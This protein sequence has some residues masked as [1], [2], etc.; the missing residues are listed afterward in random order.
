M[1][2]SPANQF[3]MRIANLVIGL[4]PPNLK[5]WGKAMRCEIDAIRVPSEATVFA[6]G[7]IYFALGQ[8]IAFFTDTAFKHLKENT[9]HMMATCAILATGLGL[10]HMTLA[11]APTSYLA[12]NAGAL[13]TGFLIVGIAAMSTKISK[14]RWGLISV[15]LALMVLLTSL[16]G[17][18]AEGATRWILLGSF[19]VQSSLLMVPIVAVVFARHQSVLTSLAIAVTSFA[20]ALQPDRGMSGA[21]AAGTLVLALAKP[22]KSSAVAAGTAMCGFV[23]AML[24]SDTLPATQ[25]VDQIYFS[26]FDV[27]PIAGIAVLAGT[28]LLIAPAI[29]GWLGGGLD[30]NMFLVFGAVWG[31]ICFAAALGNYPTPIVGYGGSAIIGY[32]VCMLAFAKPLRRGS[33]AGETASGSARKLNQTPDLRAVHA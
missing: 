20:L 27:H 5:D 19:S 8:R 17:N 21:L 6:I 25:F 2:H 15:L 30:R 4:L 31:A 12:M 3:A 13:V 24:Q 1:N 29:I 22:A 33:S 16:F 11:K 10:V 18:S 26:A 14:S 32:V 28:L 23:I 7:C 9:S